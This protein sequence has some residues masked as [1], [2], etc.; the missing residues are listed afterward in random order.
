[1]KRVGLSVV[2]LALAGTLLAAPADANGGRPGG[3]GGETAGNNLSV[4]AIFVGGTVGGPTLRVPCGN[5]PQAP[6]ADGVAAIGDS[7][8]PYVGYWLQKSEATWSATCSVAGSASV[9]LD[10]GDNLTGTTALASGKTIRVEA[11]LIDPAAT[12]RTGYV[13]ENLSTGLLDRLSVYGTNGTTFTSAAGDGANGPTATRV[14][15]PDVRLDINLVDADGTFVASKYSGAMSA[16]INS[17]GAIVYGFN[18]GMKGAPPE[19]GHYVIVVTVSGHTTIT[20]VQDWDANRMRISE[21]RHSTSLAVTLTPR[22]GKS[23]R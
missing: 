23:G 13:I 15:D 6:G 22:G 19:A 3:V 17:M 7:T 12:G 8:S 16:E 2:A 4:P 14:W 1:M 18:W 11:S 5:S 9:V 21:D 10:W 20:G